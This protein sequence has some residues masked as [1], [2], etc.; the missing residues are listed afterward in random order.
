[1]QPFRSIGGLLLM[2]GVM[3]GA[4][5]LSMWLVGAHR[6]RL[7]RRLAKAPRMTCRELAEARFLPRR[8]IITGRVVQGPA[9]PLRAPV[10]NKLCVW[11]RVD[12][13][14][15]VPGLEV[16]HFTVRHR[17]EGMITVQDDTGTVLV[18]A[19]ALDRY[20]AATDVG[21]D[22]TCEVPRHTV[23]DKKQHKDVCER[24]RAAGVWDRP[25][26]VEG[27][28]F[29][30]MRVEAGRELTILGTP[31]RRGAD[32]WVLEARQG[33]GSSGHADRAPGEQDR[34]G[35]PRP[36]CS[37]PRTRLVAGLTETALK[38]LTW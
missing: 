21:N 30:E 29:H 13:S 35:P 3:A 4:V 2:L 10:S 37:F 12:I 6:G 24:L 16:K 1:V 5:G 15:H 33:D 18:S 38:V 36:Q 26:S 34:R 9:E 14:G 23:P 27:L 19:R 17:A 22:F 28:S 32:G 31:R 7:G 20:I 8:V 25:T 11:Y